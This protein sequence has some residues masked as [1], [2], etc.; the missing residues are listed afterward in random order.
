MEAA[1]DGCSAVTPHLPFFILI[2]MS[3]IEQN[4]N[5][6]EEHTLCTVP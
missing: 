2:W 3:K 1:K 4:A 6:S 5:L